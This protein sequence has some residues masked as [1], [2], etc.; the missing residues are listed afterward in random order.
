MRWEL[1]VFEVHPVDN[2]YTITA[3]LCR[4]EEGR[5]RERVITRVCHL[6]EGI[7]EQIK[8]FEEAIVDGDYDE[9]EL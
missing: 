7:G 5:Y 9:T 1:I 2:G 8:L 4:K 3:R 6:P